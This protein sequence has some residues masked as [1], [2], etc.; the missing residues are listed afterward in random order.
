MVFLCGIIIYI[1]VERVKIFNY[2]VTLSETIRQVLE[3]YERK[4][5]KRALQERT[6]CYI[7]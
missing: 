3:D 7:L 4:S 2:S 1:L 5:A 6:L